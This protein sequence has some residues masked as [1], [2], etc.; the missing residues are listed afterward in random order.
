MVVPQL[1]KL[2]AYLQQIEG[3]SD[4]ENERSLDM[5]KGPE[6]AETSPSHDS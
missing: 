2:M 5:L 6:L 1:P 4:P 3:S